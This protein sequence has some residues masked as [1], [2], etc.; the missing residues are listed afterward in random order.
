VTDAKTM[1]GIDYIRLVRF[2]YHLT[3]SSAISGALLFAEEVGPPLFASLLLLYISFNVLLYG[4]IYTMN[5]LADLAS[6]AQHSTKRNRPLPA[7]RVSTQSAAVFSFVLTAL[8]LASGAWLFGTHLFSVYVGALFLNVFYTF[9]AKQVPYLELV[10]NSLTHPLRFLGGVL[11]AGER[12]PYA[13][14][15]AVFFLAFGFAVCRRVVEKDVE[16]WE[17]RKTLPSYSDR[18]LVTLI[19]L[20]FLGILTLAGTDPVHPRSVYQ[21]IV[22]VYLVFVYGSCFSWPVRGWLRA[23][24]TT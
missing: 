4:G 22:L 14:L 12:A 11:L 24:W 13:L 3:F 10:V 1:R 6:D 17:C 23:I 18:E 8:G 20:S 21:G 7:R 16:G 19:T 9:F 15:A 5:G 2:H